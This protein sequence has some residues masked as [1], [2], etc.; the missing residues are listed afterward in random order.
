MTTKRE[1]FY[2]YPSKEHFIPVRLRKTTVSSESGATEVLWEKRVSNYP[3]LS[4][5]LDSVIATLSEIRDEME[6][7]QIIV[8]YDE[9]SLSGSGVVYT[10]Q[11]WSSAEATE[12]E[13]A[14]AEAAGPYATT[15]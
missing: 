5:D 14:A 8:E 10:I 12:E 6:D 15:L 2:V 4:G 9:S 11:G 1:L 7:G 3:D 13:I